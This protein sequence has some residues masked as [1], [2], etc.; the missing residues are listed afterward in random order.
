MNTKK[1]KNLVATRFKVV[2]TRLKVVV[3]R[4][5]VVTTR[6]KVV[7]TRL[8]VVTT[9]LKVVVTRLQRRATRQVPGLRK[10]NVDV[11]LNIIINDWDIKS[12]DTLCAFSLYLSR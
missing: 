7:T 4:F 1:K 8:K 6:F 9:R 11:Y 3:T 10:K 2:A 5:K 12:L